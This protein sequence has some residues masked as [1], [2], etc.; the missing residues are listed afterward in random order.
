VPPILCVHVC[1]QLRA[2]C[3]VARELV[4]VCVWCVCVCVVC[5]CECECVFLCV[6]ACVH[7]FA[8]MPAH[9][10]QL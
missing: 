2:C 9:A 6:C 7:V 8:S 4:C 5:E 10:L 1:R 3:V